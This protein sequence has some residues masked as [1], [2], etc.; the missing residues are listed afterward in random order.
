M[1]ECS[2]EQFVYWI[3]F[4]KTW[5]LTILLCRVS[6]N[7]ADMDRYY[8][9]CARVLRMR[10]MLSQL[11]FIVGSCIFGPLFNAFLWYHFDWFVIEQRCLFFVCVLCSSTD[12]LLMC[13]QYGHTR[14]GHAGELRVGSHPDPQ[15]TMCLC[16]RSS[17]SF[18]FMRLCPWTSSAPPPCSWW[19]TSS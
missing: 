13:Q 2:L 9:I 7:L 12:G 10:E 6:N 8:L 5:L 15:C 14:A 1:E 16:K 18:F 11:R 3:M 4:L 19:R 17:A